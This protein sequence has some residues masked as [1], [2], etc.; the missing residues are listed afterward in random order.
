[1]Q[2]IVTTT[3][4]ALIEVWR[5]DDLYY[6]RPAGQAAPPE[7]CVGMDLFEVIADLGGLDLEDEAESAEATGLAFEA[8]RRLDSG[9]GVE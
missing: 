9:V 1:V 4:G 8:Q 2:T 7:V 5:D 3:T 6:A